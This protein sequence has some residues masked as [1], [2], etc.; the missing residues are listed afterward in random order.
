[1]WTLRADVAGDLARVLDTSSPAWIALTDPGTELIALARDRGCDVV[2]TVRA[3]G[4]DTLTRL[5]DLPLP[6]TVSMQRVD[7]QGGVG[8]I[9]VEEALLV[10]VLHG[11]GDASSVRRDLPLEADALRLLPGVTLLAAVDRGGSCVAT[12]GTRV[13]GR[14]ALVSAVATIPQYRRQGIAAALTAAALRAA[15]RAGARRAFLDAT[16]GEGVY[17]RVGFAP[18]G[19]VTRCERAPAES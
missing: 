16:D 17:T 4:R 11:G 5:P 18:L 19:L 7:L 3:M 8:A 10:D 14:S 1:M 2:H 15:E 9:S 12:A 13:V 6:P